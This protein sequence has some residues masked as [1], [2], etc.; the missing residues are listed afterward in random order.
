[1]NEWMNEEEEKRMIQGISWWAYFKDMAFL[2][3]FFN[4]TA[5]VVKECDKSNLRSSW[6]SAAAKI[7]IKIGRDWSRLVAIG[8]GRTGTR[9]PLVRYFTVRCGAVWLSRG[10]FCFTSGDFF[11]FLG[12]TINFYWLDNMHGNNQVVTPRM[13]TYSLCLIK[14][15]TILKCRSHVEGG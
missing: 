3:F 11:I 7:K 9:L 6:L 4:L 10:A 14:Y 8:R 15:T 1:M 5:S 2:S 13:T 12:L